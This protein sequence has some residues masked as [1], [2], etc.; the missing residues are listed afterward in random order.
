MISGH[1][2]RM[3]R[4]DQ[5]AL[6]QFRST[7]QHGLVNFDQSASPLLF[8]TEEHTLDKTPSR[9]TGRK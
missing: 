7:P 9:V 6:T 4:F 8:N 2:S 5:D 3:P 1:A